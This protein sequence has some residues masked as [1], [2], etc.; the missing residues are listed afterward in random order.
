MRIYL[1]I[2]NQ[3]LNVFFPRLI[4]EIFHMQTLWMQALLS[5]FVVNQQFGEVEKEPC[6]HLK[7][8]DLIWVA[9]NSI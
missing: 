7:L 3:L 1:K 8:L 2:T 4:S 9:E 5:W 6:I